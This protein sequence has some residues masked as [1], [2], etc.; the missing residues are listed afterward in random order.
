MAPPEIVTLSFAVHALAPLLPGFH[1]RYPQLRLSLDLDDRMVNIVA[2]V[3][4]MGICALPSFIV[5]EDLGAGRLE[6]VLANWRAPTLAL[7]EVWPSRRF[8]PAKGARLRRQSGRVPLGMEWVTGHPG[9]K[10]TEYENAVS[11][12]VH[13]EAFRRLNMAGPPAPHGKL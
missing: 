11:V 13:F 3:A 1:T 9:Q 5:A 4:G 12:F 7:S 6:R 2:A 10:Q 8:I